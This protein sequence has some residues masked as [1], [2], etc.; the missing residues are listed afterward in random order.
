MESASVDRSSG[1]A[2][3]FG[4]AV[5][6]WQPLLFWDPGHSQFRAAV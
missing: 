4:Q 1:A 6:C 5:G 2:H 3:L